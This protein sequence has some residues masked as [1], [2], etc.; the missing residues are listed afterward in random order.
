MNIV[1]DHVSKK[2]GKKTVIDDVSFNI[3]S[4]TITGL[5]GVNG[6]GKTMIMRLIS[7]LIYATSGKVLIDNK[8]L[9]KELSFPE[10]IGIMLENPAFLNGYSGYDNLRILADIQSKI[11]EERICEVMKLVGLEEGEKRNTKNSHSA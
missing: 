7:G 11:N 2:I 1:F 8:E 6:S 5:K 9:G 10:S 4:N 3:K